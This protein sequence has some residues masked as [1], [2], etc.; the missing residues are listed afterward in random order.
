M[1][2]RGVRKPGAWTTTSKLSGAFMQE[3]ATRL[4]LFTLLGS[5]LRG[6]AR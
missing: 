3:P 2:Y 1:C 5:R 6:E 4:E